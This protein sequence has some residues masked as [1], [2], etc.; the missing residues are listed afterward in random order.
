VTEQEAY[1]EGT[2]DPSD[3]RV[4]CTSILAGVTDWR[5]L[6]GLVKARINR[7]SLVPD[8]SAQTT[9]SA[10]AVLADMYPTSLIAA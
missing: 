2:Y 10:A 1:R 3:R 7:L 8:G 4:S 9:S 5:V 6:N